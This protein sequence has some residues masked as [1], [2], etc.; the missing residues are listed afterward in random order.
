[1]VLASYRG[2][3]ID[4]GRRLQPALAALAAANH[5]HLGLDPRAR[6]LVL[7]VVAVH[8]SDTPQQQ[9]AAE[10][11]EL[12]GPQLAQLSVVAAWRRLVEAAAGGGIE[13]AVAGVLG[14]VE[15]APPLAV[16]RKLH[17]E[18]ILIEQSA[19]EC[20]RACQPSAKE[21]YD[22]PGRGGRGPTF[23]SS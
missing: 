23:L 5:P 4:E 18:A 20:V 19:T 1:M 7:A 21:R 9:I 14:K 10:Q 13:V 3:G 2:L 17:H 8:F 22:G 16:A 15:P 6:S 12:I 11:L